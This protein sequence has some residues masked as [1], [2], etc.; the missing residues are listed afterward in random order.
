MVVKVIFTFVG[1]MIG[2]LQY[3]LIKT[4]AKY[5][6]EKHGGVAGIIAAK[7]LLYVLSAATVFVWFK[8]CIFVFATGLVAGIILCA[9]TDNLR[10]KKQ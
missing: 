4:A 7:I 9:V 3:G 2:L 8:D 6:A 5:A 10:S 1:L